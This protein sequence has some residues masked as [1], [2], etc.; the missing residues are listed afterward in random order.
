VRVR[1]GRYE[2][3][4]IFLLPQCLVRSRQPQELH[5][6]RELG[7]RQDPRRYRD[8]A[9]NTCRGPT[10]RKLTGPLCKVSYENQAR[11]HYESI[12]SQ[13]R[14]APSA[15][16]AYDANAS[17]FSNLRNLAARVPADHTPPRL[18]APATPRA[19]CNVDGPH[20]IICA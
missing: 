1:K 12:I 5:G 10:I 8:L 15:R 2:S 17:E 13:K 7:G 20:G 4:T 19:A 3:L 11:D 14:R 6:V 16:V 18:P 9:N